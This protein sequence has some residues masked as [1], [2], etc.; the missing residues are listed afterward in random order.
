MG[1]KEEE[2][3]M[4]ENSSTKFGHSKLFFKSNCSDLPEGDWRVELQ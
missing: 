1:L 2:R 3:G 4:E